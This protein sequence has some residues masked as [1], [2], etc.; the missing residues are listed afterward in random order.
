MQPPSVSHFCDAAWVMFQQSMT[1]PEPVMPL[2]HLGSVS[3]PSA[4]YPLKI[5]LLTGK[6]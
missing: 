3:N 1:I 5:L 6:I 2:K 4:A